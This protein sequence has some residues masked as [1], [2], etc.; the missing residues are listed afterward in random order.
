M[1]FTN[2]S[3]ALRSLLKS[4]SITYK[5]LADKLDMSESGIKKLLTSDD[6]SFNK[7]NA[8][9]SVLDVTLKDLISLKSQGY[10]KLTEKQENFLIKHPQHLNFFIQ[11]HHHWIDVEALKAE[12]HKLSKAKMNQYIDDLVKIEVLEWVDGKLTS[13]LKDGFTTS[14]KFNEQLQK[15][16]YGVVIGSLKNAD[17]YKKSPWLYEGFGHFDLTHKSALELKMALDDLMKEFSK[18]TDREKKLHK[19]SDL[20]HCTALLINTDLKVKDVFPI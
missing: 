6:I 11:L 4:R 3:E 14:D 10:A 15:R 13:S 18:R 20:V 5:D 12:N 1:E 7:L 8:I 17:E 9:L 16:M 2:V 19:K